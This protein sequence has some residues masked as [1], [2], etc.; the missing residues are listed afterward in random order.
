[1]DKYGNSYTASSR[2][3]LVVMHVAATGRDVVVN[4]DFRSLSGLTSSPS[5]QLW[6]SDTKSIG[7]FKVIP[8]PFFT[9]L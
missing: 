9:Q 7:L 8:T 3:H 5:G 4:R 1:M 2:Y 6:I